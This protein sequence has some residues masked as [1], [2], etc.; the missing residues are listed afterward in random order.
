MTGIVIVSYRSDDAT[1]RFV[2]EQIGGQDE[3]CPVV[4]VA[5]GSSEAEA[6][7]LE[8]RMNGVTVLP[9]DNIGY[10]RGNNLGAEWLQ[11]HVHPDLILFVNNDIRFSSPDVIR[12]MGI[13]LS[14]NPDAGV[15]GPEIVGLDGRRQSPEPY[16][17]L[18]DRYVWMYLMTPF[19]SQER[20]WERFGLDYSEKAGEGFHYKLM[21]SCLMVRSADFFRCGGFDPATF[22]FGEE[23][24]LAERMHSIGRQCY[25]YPAVR[26]VHEHGATVRKHLDERRASRLQFQSMAYYYHTYRNVSSFSIFS[27]RLFFELYLL[28]K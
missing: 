11:E 8:G 2:Q 20:K 16:M 27:A 7:A 14:G 10:A 19:L 15:L 25:F 18:G 1:V 24:I 6:R 5:N 12:R 23:N 13:R 22:L 4:V 28:V 17:S 26:V 9:A 21:G 3:S